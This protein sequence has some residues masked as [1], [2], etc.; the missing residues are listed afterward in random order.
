LTLFHAPGTLFSHHFEGT[1]VRY[2]ITGITGFVGPHLA[3]LLLENGHEVWGFVRA[4]NGREDDIREIVPDRNFER[5][6]F[7]YGDLTD[8][9]SCKRAMQAQK[10]DGV[11]HLAAQSHPPTSFDDPRGTFFANAVGTVNLAEAIRSVSP[12]CRLMFCSTSEVYGA[13]A[14]SE[15]PIHENFPIRPVNPY[16]VSKAA[17][18]LYVRERAASEKLHFFVTRAFSHTG[19]RRGRRFSIASDVYQIVRIQKGFQEPVIKVGTLSSKRVVMDVR[20]GCR[21]YYLLMQH[22]APGEAYNV[23]GDELFTIGQ[24][25]ELMLE[26]TGLKDRVRLEVDPKLVRPIDIPVQICDTRKCRQLTGWK[27]EI[28]I[29]KMLADLLEY[30]TRKIQ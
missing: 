15:G 7:I 12:A 23:G 5:L 16:G 8:Y 19:P 27:P 6:K 20:D 13:P 1:S 18:D 11:F 21:A 25:L 24:L 14:E 22:S 10:F 3:N 2:L 30:Y 28:P 29:R 9:D 17:A 4:S 26:M